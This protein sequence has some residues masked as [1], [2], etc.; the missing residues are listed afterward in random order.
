M[1]STIEQA[2]AALVVSQQAVT[3]ATTL[4]AYIRAAGFPA[5]CAEA[6]RAFEHALDKHPARAP[7]AIRAL[8]AE[9]WA[10]KLGGAHASCCCVACPACGGMRLADRAGV[11]EPARVE[12]KCSGWLLIVI[13]MWRADVY[14]AGGKIRKV[15]RTKPLKSAVAARPV[16]DPYGPS[17]SAVSI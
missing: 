12:K 8:R 7:D 2:V 10:D 3:V 4:P 6:V 11:E 15:R 17:T 5:L 16:V 13:L 14:S 9:Y 1:P